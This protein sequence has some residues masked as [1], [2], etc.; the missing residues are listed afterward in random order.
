MEPPQPSSD[1][2]TK[3]FP[4]GRRI[5]FAEGKPTDVID[6]ILKSQP[7]NEKSRTEVKFDNLDELFRSIETFTDGI[8][9]TLCIPT[10]SRW[11]ALLNN[12]Y[13]F[14]SDDSF[15]W[16]ITTDLNTPSV[17]WTACTHSLC[18]TVK[19]Y[20]K[21]EADDIAQER[22]IQMFQRENGYIYFCATGE[23]LKEELVE[24]YRNKK[25]LEK[26]SI[27]LSLQLLKKLSITPWDEGFYDLSQPFTVI[28]QS[29]G[30]PKDFQQV[31]SAVYSEIE[32]YKDI[33]IPPIVEM[34]DNISDP[35]MGP[36]PLI[37]LENF[38]EGN[39]DPSSIG[40]NLFDDHPGL[41][42]F[43]ETLKEIRSR[44]NVAEVLVG[45]ADLAEGD[46]PFSD[47]V[48]IITTA[49]ATEVK[50]WMEPLHPDTITPPHN[51]P[52]NLGEFP[53]GHQVLM[54]WWD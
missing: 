52:A 4:L 35:A 17:N 20:K 15:C 3:W 36:T 6:A 34:I 14:N 27:D 12:D 26:F 8:S 54:A 24:N 41:K 44:E 18:A 46:W 32:I 5:D 37:S 13:N 31:L 2:I 47:S 16:D 53:A 38:F 11:I 42:G 22:W 9:K 21:N 39:N 29:A 30:K 7:W 43:Y 25:K 45:I 50:K 1:V 10:K 40:C 33:T 19:H 23:P 28:E 48:W 49:N 51:E